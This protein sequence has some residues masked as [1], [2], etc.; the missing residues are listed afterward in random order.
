MKSKVFVAYD[1]E[2]WSFHNISLQ[3]MRYL[4]DEYD[5][6]LSPYMEVQPDGRRFLAE[7]DAVIC[8][9][10]GAFSHLRQ[11]P[12]WAPWLE[13]AS[14]P[15]CKWI[16]CVFDEV[17]RWNSDQA[18]EALVQACLEADSILIACKGMGYRLFPELPT[19]R[20][21]G[22]CRDGVDPELF[23]PR[24]YRRDLHSTPLR[25]GW[26]GNSAN[27]FFG[28]IKGLEQIKAACS[29]L[30]GVNLCY[31][32]KAEH[33]LIPHDKMSASFEAIDVLVCFSACEGTP[34][35]ILEA[36]STGRAWV[37]T[38][39]GIVPELMQ[40]ALAMGHITPP[41]III[42]R[43]PSMLRRALEILRDDRDLCVRMGEVS[44]A[45]IARHWTWRTKVEQYRVALHT[46]GV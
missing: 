43:E 6:F 23:P 7:A 36:A 10:Y 4:S 44:R 1:C 28:S 27:E 37:S 19:P 13:S 2:G 15:D 35:P 42:P 20:N 24:R 33:G 12:T 38:N 8:L 34:N 3:I 25:V 29:H 30:D 46:V 16:A 39:V 32:D 5:I 14:K 40:D 17:L 21:L 26:T 9:W 41:G 18:R 11:R 22:L 45:V 31:H